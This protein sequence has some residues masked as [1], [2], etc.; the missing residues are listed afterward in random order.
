MDPDQ[1]LETLR[2]LLSSDD[3]D[4]LAGEVF[5]AL[6]EWIMNGGFLPKDWVMTKPQ[7]SADGTR[8][9]SQ[10][11]RNR[12]WIMCGNYNVPFREDNY[13][14]DGYGYAC[15]WIGG[16]EHATADRG[17]TKKPTI[18]TGVSPEGESHT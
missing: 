12:L 8:R 3:E 2:E 14:I 13:Y 18:Y 15:G 7:E 6:D 10:A 1:N 4:N 16:N 9:M 5:K 11:Q 17:G